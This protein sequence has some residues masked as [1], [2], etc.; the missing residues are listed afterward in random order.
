MTTPIPIPVRVTPTDVT[1]L[2][3]PL[4]A[5]TAMVLHR[6]YAGP[7]QRNGTPVTSTKRVDIVLRPRD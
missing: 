3:H 2:T 4:P 7:W 1:A 5:P 6:G